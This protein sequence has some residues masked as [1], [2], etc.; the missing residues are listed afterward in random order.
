MSLLYSILKMLNLKDENIAFFEDFYS[1]RIIKGVRSQVYR[2]KLTYRPKKCACCGHVMDDNIIKHGFKASLITLPNVSH[3]K[4]YLELKK[5]RMLCR[6]CNTTFT[7]QTSVVEPNCSI[8]N[9]TKHAIAL[10]AANKVSECDLAKRHNVSHSTVNRIINSFY[11]THRT[12]VVDLP[13]SLCF[14]EFKSVKEA[15]GAMSFIYCNADTGELIDIVEDRRLHS[16]KKYFARFPKEVRHKVK[17]IVI[18]MYSPYMSLIKKYFPKAKI[19][20]DKFHFVQLLSRALNKTRIERMKYDKANY[21][22]LKRYWKLLLKRRSKIDFKNYQSYTCFKGLMCEEDVLNYLLSLSTELRDTYELYQ[23]LISCIEIKEKD[24]EIPTT[25]EN[26]EHRTKRLVSILS[27]YK[28]N[29]PH[30]SNYMETAI[31]TLLQYKDFVLNMMDTDLTNGP[32]EGL[33]NK[34][35]LIK[36]ISFGYRSFYHLKARIMMTQKMQQLQKGPSSSYAA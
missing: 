22:K 32:I 2:A 25:T 18:D 26:K 31:T 15:T 20:I 12:Q 30:L 33:I 6:H 9:N 4:A 19:I 14:D 3:M 16:L 34:I 5:Q 35:K 27:N 23:D 29:Y 36:R 1:E 13:E 28:Q 8:S 7:L 10:D 17:H 11:E 24:A 21:N